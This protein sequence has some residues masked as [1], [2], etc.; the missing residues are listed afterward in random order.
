MR[1]GKPE[2][3]PEP[4]PAPTPPPPPP[5]D[6]AQE[7]PPAVPGDAAAMAAWWDP[8]LQFFAR[9]RAAAALA[10]WLG[11][12]GFDAMDLHMP[13]E[14]LVFTF[15]SLSVFVQAFGMSALL[16][17][18][19]TAA[20][21]V[22]N[23][24]VYWL[25]PFSTTS[26]LSTVVVCMLLV[27]GVHGL[28]SRGW[29]IAALM[30]LSR[31]GTPWC[32]ALPA[33]LQAPVAAYCAS[34]GLLWIAYHS[35]RRLESLVDPLCLLLGIVPPLPL[36]LSIAEIGGTS[37]VLRWARDHHPGAGES[38][39][40]I[41]C[42]GT[43]E[44]TRLPDARPAHYEVEVDGR[45]VGWCSCPAEAVRVRG[46]QPGCTYQVRV[47][48]L[49][50]SRGRAPSAPV[51]VQTLAAPA[52]AQQDPAQPTAAEIESIRREIADA[53]REAA[54]MEASA[55]ALTQQAEAECAALQA[56][57]AE[58]RAARK[59]Q[60]GARAALRSEIRELEAEKRRA[61]KETAALRSAIAEADSRWQRAQ[62]RR[63][64]RERRAEERRRSVQQLQAKMAR[65]LSDH[66]RE[67][68]GARAAIDSLKAQ[69]GLAEQRARE[70]ARE[71][72]A[73]ARELRDK[74]REAAAQ[75]KENAAL[76][77]RVRHAAQRRRQLRTARRE[78]AA[79][80]ARLQ[81][82]VDLLEA[83][84]SEAVAQRQQREAAAA[85][86]AAAVSPPAVARPP[87]VYPAAMPFP[88]ASLPPRLR[89]SSDLVSPDS[90]RAGPR[91]SRSSSFAVGSPA[92]AGALPPLR[93]A[94]QRGLPSIA[95]LRSADGAGGATA[96]VA[97]LGFGGEVPARRSADLGDLLG[98][99]RGAQDAPSAAMPTTAAEASALSILKDTDLAYPTPKRTEYGGGGGGGGGGGWLGDSS[100]SRVPFPQPPPEAHAGIAGKLH[101][102]VLS[103]MLADQPARHAGLGTPDLCVAGGWPDPELRRYPSPLGGEAGPF[104]LRPASPAEQQQ[105]LFSGDVLGM[106]RPPNIAA[107][108][109]NGRPHVAPIGAPAKSRRDNLAAL[110]MSPA[111]S[112]DHLPLAGAVHSA[113]TDSS[114]APLRAAGSQS[115]RV[116]MD[117]GA[118]GSPPFNESLYCDR[119][120]W[121]QDAASTDD[122]R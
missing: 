104:V 74:R 84:L 93:Y 117:H 31:L 53:D 14:W 68:A 54:E 72:D 81:A 94:A 62:Q 33:Y 118:A 20:M 22:L 69:V 5:P 6:P 121:E 47:W 122:P 91:H 29:A 59:E 58:L 42:L 56:Q 16:F 11:V 83:Q 13:A 40:R 92:V 34:F 8:A 70:L 45:I 79:T 95:G 55:A 119:S 44:R 52:S 36:C 61:D 43:L 18:A 25:L 19:L 65:E 27:R 86:A 63:R 60:D 71:K 21:T 101:R 2:P 49:S 3:A 67:Q 35:S 110:K 75:E 113:S 17:T 98:L 96:S 103:R 26:L 10:A 114:D 73:A 51:F 37:V 87:P 64:D 112:H 82:E 7:P 97:A 89:G 12:L 1:P 57:A 111:R 80:A 9:H 107:P 76:E 108:V 105:H 32:R 99:W 88:P 50:R 66:E 78:A 100:Y 106:R 120:F 46:L 77:S 115:C 85:A 28:D 109:G 41:G 15:F 90:A 38:A 4:A 30:S 116:S 24:G 102:Q 39:V 23:V 48:A